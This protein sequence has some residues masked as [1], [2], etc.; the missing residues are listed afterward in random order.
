MRLSPHSKSAAL[1]ERQADAKTDFSNTGIT[2]IGLYDMNAAIMLL[3]R[4][5][6]GIHAVWGV[7]HGQREREHRS[8]TRTGSPGASGA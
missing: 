6:S 5:G 3:Q 7:R 1:A 8:Q 2:S 4:H